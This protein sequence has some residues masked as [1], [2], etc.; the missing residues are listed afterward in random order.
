MCE[1]LTLADSDTAE[2]VIKNTGFFTE[3]SVR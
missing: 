1:F 2:H 3:D